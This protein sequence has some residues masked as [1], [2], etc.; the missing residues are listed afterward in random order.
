MPDTPG[1]R[2]RREVKAKKRQARE[3]RRDARKARQNDPTAGPND[4]LADEEYISK[5]AGV[6]QAPARES[7][8][9]RPVA[10][11]PAAETARDPATETG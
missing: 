4:W 1:K 3:E 5:T 8:A 11:S 9:P 7:R 2:Q 6:P 10:D